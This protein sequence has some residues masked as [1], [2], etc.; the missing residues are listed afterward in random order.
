MPL[1]SGYSQK[2]ISA[3]VAELIRANKRKS[4]QE[5]RSRKQIVAIALSKAREAKESVGKPLTVA[6]RLAERAHKRRSA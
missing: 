6:D 2:T 1:Q 3:N 5:R 4:P